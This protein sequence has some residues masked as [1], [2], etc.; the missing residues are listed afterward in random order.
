RERLRAERGAEWA[1]VRS[2]KL[3]ELAA[4]F[5]AIHSV[6]RAVEVGS[7]DRIVPASELRPY[8]IDAVERGIARTRAGLSAGNGSHRQRAATSST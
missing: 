6:Q 7:V 1:A 5:D 3:G 4:E 8:L 2:E